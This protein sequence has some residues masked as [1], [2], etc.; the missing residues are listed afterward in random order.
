MLLTSIKFFRKR[1][2]FESFSIQ[3]SFYIQAK[4]KFRKFSVQIRLA[5]YSS[6]FNDLFKLQ[7]IHT[8]FVFYLSLSYHSLKILSFSEISDSIFCLV[9]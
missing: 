7:K 3:R 5:N 8:R 2:Y 4:D 9:K 1:I 6:Q